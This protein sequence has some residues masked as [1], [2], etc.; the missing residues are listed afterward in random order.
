MFLSENLSS[1]FYEPTL[2]WLLGGE[3]TTGAYLPK[4]HWGL[5]ILPL[6]FLPPPASS[7]VPAGHNHRHS[8]SWP[9]P[10]LFPRLPFCLEI[11]SQLQI[12]GVLENNFRPSLCDAL[13]G[14]LSSEGKLL[15]RK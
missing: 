2:D 12:P 7:L 1:V 11:S 4:L 8:Y 14:F 9:Y 5:L 15:E 13:S 10:C 3:Q 6:Q